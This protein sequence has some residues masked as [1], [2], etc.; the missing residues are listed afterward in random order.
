[1]WTTWDGEHEESFSLTWD[2]EAWTASGHVGRE[3]VQ[4]IIRLSPLWQVRQFMLFRDLDQPDLWLGTDGHGRWGEMNGAHRPDL[5]G[6]IDVA[7]VVTPF[8]HALP[9]RRLPLHV[10]DSAKLSVLAIDVETLGVTTQLVTYVRTGLRSWRVDRGDP[11]EP[12]SIELTVDEHGVPLEVL[13]WF[14]S[15]QV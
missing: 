10:G 3:D 4:Y 9:I 15:H 8:T 12:T 11:A 5:D 2:N 13:G 14:R 6:P 7:L 1:M